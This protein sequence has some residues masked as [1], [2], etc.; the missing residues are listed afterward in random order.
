MGLQPTDDLNTGAGV[1]AGPFHPAFGE[2]VYSALWRSALQQWLSRRQLQGQPLE[3]TVHPAVLSRLRGHRNENVEWIQNEF[4]P[5]CIHV[6]TSATVSG[7]QALING[8]ACHLF[9]D[10]DQ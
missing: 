4:K 7:E 8:A 1:V 6:R 10:H 2:L 5:A 3:I 9:Y